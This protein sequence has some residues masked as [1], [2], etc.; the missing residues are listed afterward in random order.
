MTLYVNTTS[1]KWDNT[2]AKIEAATLPDGF[3]DYSIENAPAAVNNRCLCFRGSQELR[4]VGWRN[5]QSAN[6]ALCGAGDL[7]KVNL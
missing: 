1:F 3:P 2:R 5:N 7:N 6:P 4:T